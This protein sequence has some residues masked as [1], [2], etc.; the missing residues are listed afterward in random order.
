MISDNLSKLNEIWT[1]E[2]NFLFCF[3]ICS[4]QTMWM[5]GIIISILMLNTNANTARHRTTTKKINTNKNAMEKCQQNILNPQKCSSCF[6]CFSIVFLRTLRTLRD[7]CINLLSIFGHFRK[8]KMLK[9]NMKYEYGFSFFF[10]VVVVSFISYVEWT[11]WR[12]FICR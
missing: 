8:N 4:A 10:V 12:V 1:L 6:M 7:V 2:S 5:F 3:Y 9:P 11:W